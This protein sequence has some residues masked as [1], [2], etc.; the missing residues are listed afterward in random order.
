MTDEIHQDVGAY[1]L[2]ALDADARARFEQHLSRCEQ[3]REELVDLVPL[4]GLMAI[5]DFEELTVSGS[6]SVSDVV[7]SA[8]G[9]YAAIETSRRRWRVASLGF[10]AAAAVAM[11]LF[12]GARADPVPTG[13]LAGDIELAI[14]S[15]EPIDGRIA[16]DERRWGTRVELDLAGLPSRDGYEVWVVTSDGS[17]EMAASFGP[18]DVSSCR[19][20]GSTKM[21]PD[22][23]AM[24]VVTTTDRAEELV[25]A[26]QP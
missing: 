5:V 15:T 26:V 22:D 1:V 11:V 6:T 14:T 23:I 2:G 8:S 16:F 21:R 9:Q 24:V 13:D 19:I 12:I 10:G 4:P 20:I 25:W 3:C 17:W 18:I 7:A